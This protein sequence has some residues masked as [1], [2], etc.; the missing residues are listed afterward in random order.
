MLASWLAVPARPIDMS[1]DGRP[2]L[3]LCYNWLDSQSHI[4]TGADT[5]KHAVLRGNQSVAL[6]LPDARSIII[7]E[8]SVRRLGLAG[9]RFLRETFPVRAEG[10]GQD[11]S[12]A[13]T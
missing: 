6:A 5:E 13:L 2:H 11:G 9:G 8:G 7:I 10:W 3:P 4:A 12:L 1:G